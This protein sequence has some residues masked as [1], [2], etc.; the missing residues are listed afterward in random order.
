MSLMFACRRSAT[1]EPFCLVGYEQT[2]SGGRSFCKY[3]TFESIDE[4]RLFLESLGDHGKTLDFYDGI[5]DIGQFLRDGSFRE[6]ETG[7]KLE[8][9]RIDVR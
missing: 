9:E 4:L 7:R 1:S 5:V 8:K 2:A 3:L 6:V